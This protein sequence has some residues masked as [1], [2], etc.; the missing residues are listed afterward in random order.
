MY[1]SHL[2]LSIRWPRGLRRG[3]EAARLLGWR[4]RM[5]CVLSGR[6]IC[7]GLITRPEKSDLLWCVWVWSCSL[8]K[9]WPWPD[10][11]SK[12]HRE[13]NIYIYTEVVGSAVMRTLLPCWNTNDSLVKNCILDLPSVLILS[14]ERRFVRRICFRLPV[15]WV[16]NMKGPLERAN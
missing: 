11:G 7:V 15:K 1:L 13:R 2:Y 10:N 5:C 16:P 6:G 3:S 9:E 12:H 8:D 4:V 14:G